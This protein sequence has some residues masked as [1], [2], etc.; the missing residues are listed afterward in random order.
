MS[1]SLNQLAGASTRSPMRSCTTPAAA[2][3]SFEIA[4]CT[5]R[6]LI[7]ISISTSIGVSASASASISKRQC[8][9]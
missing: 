8:H 5:W 4:A 7:S 6:L 9:Y 3:I 2:F 1:R